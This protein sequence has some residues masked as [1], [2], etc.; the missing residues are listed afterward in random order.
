MK[1]LLLVLLSFIC[2]TVQAQTLKNF[3][4]TAD[5]CLSNLNKSA[6]TT[7]ILYDRVYPFAALS[8]FNQN[9]ADTSSSSHFNQAYNELFNAAYSNAGMVIPDTVSGRLTRKLLSGIV[10]IGII[11]YRFNY[12]DTT[13]I[14]NNLIT[15]SGLLLYDVPNR[16]RSPFLESSLSLAAVL[17]DSITTASPYFELS[18]SLYLNNTGNTISNL[19]IDFGDGSGLHQLSLGQGISINY[20]S[21]GNKTVHY[22]INYTSGLQVET[23]S[24]LYV[25]LPE[26]S[27][28]SA[29]KG[30]T[31]QG[32]PPACNGFSAPIVL[33][34]I[35]ADIGFQGYSGE[36]TP[37]LGQGQAT[38]IYHTNTCDQVLRKPIII[39]DG[40]DPGSHL[41]LDYFHASLNYN[42]NQNNFGDEMLAKGY[43]IVY[44][45]YP[46]YSR[47]GVSIDGGADYIQRN[48][49]TLIKLIQT[50]NT[51]LQQN[52]STEK[53]V[54][55]GPSMGG[56]ISRYALSY[57]E[58]NNM[59]HNTR[60]WVS[61]D[62]PHLGANIPIGDQW[63]LD[64]LGNTLGLS[65]AKLKLDS[66]INSPAAKEMLLHHYS[67]G[68]ESP[69]PNSFRNS[70]MQDLNTLGY[71]SQL[72]KM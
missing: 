41:K 17:I 47:N 22:F 23:Y 38:V 20:P 45:Y 50:V 1:K 68:A 40:F 72:R 12:L 65:P 7:N 71:P 44:L 15:T 14:Q 69:T 62:S 53:I 54:I 4:Q 10:P 26:S 36:T 8:V 31:P 59:P 3:T 58:R 24:S 64:Y 5:S 67:T 35:I 2:L 18:S 56:L 6:M 63:T 49:Y 57:M 55:V 70:F 32:A 34:P 51:K 11:N 30:P 61:F 9:Y 13:S 42:N 39:I 19:S 60:L 33:D 27:N 28:F 52:G 29:R 48:A 46:G 43:D 66:T 16:S 25:L 21:S 37:S